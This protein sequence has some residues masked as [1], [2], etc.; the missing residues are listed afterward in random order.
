MDSKLPNGGFPPIVECLFEINKKIK[1]E[2]YLQSNMKN[3][4]INKILNTKKEKL[5]ILDDDK[6]LIE[7]DEV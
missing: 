5:N 6:E 1:K 4:N 3:I 7:L 2:R